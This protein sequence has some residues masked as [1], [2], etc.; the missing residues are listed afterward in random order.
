M[1]LSPLNARQLIVHGHIVIGSRI[2]TV[3]GY[4]VGGQEEGVIKLIG[5]G[6]KERPEAPEVAAPAPAVQDQEAPQPQA[7]EPA[8]AE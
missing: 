8:K 2:I 5:G 4:E 7:E 3:P 6:A 1:A